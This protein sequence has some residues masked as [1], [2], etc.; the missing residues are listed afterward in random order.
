MR[1][2]KFSLVWMLS[3]IMVAF[4]SCKDDSTTEKPILVEDGI[5]VVGEAT[6]FPELDS[7][8]L[9]KQATNE[10]DNNAVRE[11]M[12]ELYTT[13]EA[14][15]TF[16]IS[17]VAGKAQTKYG[18]SAVA[19]EFFSY[20]PNGKAE[21]PKVTL[22]MGKY[23]AGATTFTV[24][25]SGL[26]HIVIDK[27]LGKVAVVPIEYWGIIGAA[28][29]GGWGADTKLELDGTFNKTAMTFKATDLILIQ[30]TYKFRYDGYW[31]LQLDDTATVVNV[32]M[33][34]VNTN[35]GGS[36]TALVAG[37]ADI[38]FA[39]ADQGKYTV[40]MK[41]TLDGGYTATLTKTGDYT[42]PSY[43]TAM[44][45][46]GSATAYGWD[47]PGTK[48]DAIMHKCAGGAPTE[49]I[50]WK[51]CYLTGGEGFKLSNANWG[52]VNL[53]FAEVASFDNTGV[54]V[55]NNGGNMSVATSGM[56]MVVLNLRDNTKK[57][58]IKPAAVYGIGDAFGG[59]NTDVAAN[60]F[61]INNTAKTLVSPAL[62][63]NGN[64]RMYASHPWIPAWWNAEFRVNGTAIEYRND[65]GDQ[66]AVAGTVGK[67][68]TLHFDD[69]TG[70][71]AK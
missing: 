71:I 57:V 42:P 10:K 62:T 5:Y 66:A 69:N 32:S 12:Y 4:I 47:T 61:T 53:G 56:Y 67:V 65:G 28:T 16:Y 58:S 14:G 38:A 36:L 7:K 29:P 51:I 70:S 15:K 19:G 33:V 41:W 55:T 20:N 21:Q 52:T 17:E 50:F 8:G 49:G 35:F 39:A 2:V 30:G 64:I 34:K 54:T 27:Q 68:I 23:V 45:I 48:A 13:V 63:A 59:F 46:V 25:T 26:Y 6:N 40:E 37:G 43:P 24:P 60:K 1:K 44:Y 9:M 18:P 3:L 31:K 11:G 22:Q